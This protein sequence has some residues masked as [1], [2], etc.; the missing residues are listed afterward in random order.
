LPSQGGCTEL[1][2]LE[3]QSGYQSYGSYDEHQTL[4]QLQPSRKKSSRAFL[5]Q[6]RQGCQLKNPYQAMQRTITCQSAEEPKQ[7]LRRLRRAAYKIDG[8]RSAVS[9]LVRLAVH[10]QDDAP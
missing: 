9:L 8:A 5:S 10:S 3:V 6:L 4:P 1:E 2:R 7:V